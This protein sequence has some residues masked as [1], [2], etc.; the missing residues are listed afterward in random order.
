M[1][2]PSRV[3]VSQ[4]GT[5]DASSTPSTR[6]ASFGGASSRVIEESTS[7]GQSRSGES[8]GNLSARS[9]GDNSARRMSSSSIITETRSSQGAAAEDIFPL[10]PGLSPKSQRTVT[11]NEEH[12]STAPSLLSLPEAR[13]H[14]TEPRHNDALNYDLVPESSMEIDAEAGD[15][16]GHAPLR[17][18]C[19]DHN[20]ITE[21][22]GGLSIRD[23]FLLRRETG[24][25]PTR[26]FSPL[27]GHRKAGVERPLSRSARAFE[28]LIRR[29]SCSVGE[30]E[31]AFETQFRYF[32]NRDARTLYKLLSKSM[33][34]SRTITLSTR[35]PSRISLADI[36]PYYDPQAYKDVKK[37]LVVIFDPT[38]DTKGLNYCLEAS[39][40]LGDR[41]HLLRTN[42]S[43]DGLT[44]GL[45]ISGA[46]WSSS[47]DRALL[48]CHTGDPMGERTNWL[49]GWA[50]VSPLFIP[51]DECHLTLSIAKRANIPMS[52]PSS[53]TSGST[54]MHNR[55]GS[56]TKKKTKGKDRPSSSSSTCQ[57]IGMDFLSSYP[58]APP[59][60]IADSVPRSPPRSAPCMFVQEPEFQEPN[61]L[62]TLRAPIVY[63]EADSMHKAMK[64]LNTIV[65][66]QLR[67]FVASG[68]SGSGVGH[69]NIAAMHG[70]M[71]VSCVYYKS[72]S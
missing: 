72:R 18:I 5:S 28:E 59:E 63:F 13:E 29:P 62:N 30:L 46:R 64:L 41:S 3:P 22:M 36:I 21:G 43:N 27:S 60:F 12:N 49:P 50:G 10:P 24:L 19:E 70:N 51:A 8:A 9:R 34:D 40:A 23:Y 37:G 69:L 44:E 16:L 48:P 14:A 71:D 7:L 57:A 54:W 26:P 45:E 38:L 35:K 55:S 66:P 56:K 42:I 47:A 11:I 31:R 65:Y 20:D 2:E 39:Y 61:E 32:A 15:S 33:S 1:E 53:C 67:A 17:V 4:I 52:R 58:L 25:S 6:R 68:G